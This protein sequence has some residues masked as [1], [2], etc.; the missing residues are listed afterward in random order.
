MRYKA[1]LVAAFS[2]VFAFFVFAKTS[3]QNL[4]EQLGIIPTNFKVY[5]EGNEIRVLKQALVMRPFV[6]TESGDISVSSPG[7][8][9]K[10]SGSIDLTHVVQAYHFEFAVESKIKKLEDDH[11]FFAQDFQLVFAGRDMK[12]LAAIRL[13]ANDVRRF[14]NGE[15][16][17]TYSICL[18][19]APLVWLDDTFSILIEKKPTGNFLKKE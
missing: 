7:A 10:Q 11:F 19:K 9:D 15:G 14:S 6:I 2:F 5:Q 17:Y 4:N 8:A 13:D 1:S 16:I 3:A 12:R 18:Q